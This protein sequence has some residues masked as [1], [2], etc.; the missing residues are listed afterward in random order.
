MGMRLTTLLLAFSLSS[1]PAWADDLA[2]LAPAH[3]DAQKAAHL[4]R[5][6]GFGGSPAEI[7][8]LARMT[9]RQ[10]VAQLLDYEKLPA[11]APVKLPLYDRKSP[12]VMRRIER[13]SKRQAKRF[14]RDVRKE[15]PLVP[16]N[17]LTRALIHRAARVETVAVLGLRH[18]EQLIR[19]LRAW[20]V[21]RMVRTQRP[22]EEKM[23]MFWHSHFA[24]GWDKVRDAHLMARQNRLLR[25][26][27]TGDFGALLRGIAR[28]PAML[29]Y[30]DGDKNVRSHPNENFARELMELFTLGIGHYTERDVKQAARAFTGW[31]YSLWGGM[32]FQFRFWQHDY[33]TKQFLGRRGRLGG[34]DIIRI[35]LA[36]PHTANR[37]ATKLLRF[38]VCA[39]PDRRWV[40]GLAASL[41]KHRY[42]LKPVLRELFL[43][44]AFY[45]PRVIG[46]QIKSPTELLVGTARLLG[47]P[48]QVVAA[49]AIHTLPRIGQS[50]FD[51]VNVKGW[52]GGRSWINTATMLSRY[53][54]TAALVRGAPATAPLRKIPAARL[55]ALLLHRPLDNQRQSLLADQHGDWA[56]TLLL[57]TSMPEYQL[58]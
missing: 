11:L 40:A 32:R 46:T 19:T 57:I 41:R 47:T 6:A 7:Q 26:H 44:R 13:R 50:L 55:S 28:D 39:N 23:T 2:P 12:A 29:R 35:L 38:F 36:S 25:K 10:A 48:S 30:L 20:W 49:H 1:F 14:M 9:P 56:R 4:L 17:K 34:D 18:D 3:W 8:R 37:L 51:P 16:D 15:V 42:Q 43:S 5:R 21:Q 53:N 45:S 22:L 58:Q 33:G 27:A 54:M 52:D 24:T 31:N